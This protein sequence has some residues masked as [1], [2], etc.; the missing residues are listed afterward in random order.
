M[1]ATTQIIIANKAQIVAYGALKRP[2]TTKAALA[3]LYRVLGQAKERKLTPLAREIQTHI[4][5]IED[6]PQASAHDCDDDTLIL[7]PEQ[8]VVPAQTHQQ[9]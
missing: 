2:D 1:N 4:F 6:Q 5:R 3:W 8:I 7:L 9:I